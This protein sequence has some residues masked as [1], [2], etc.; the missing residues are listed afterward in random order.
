MLNS[1]VL[2]GFMLYIYIIK[3]TEKILIGGQA[4]R[5]L[6]HDRHTDDYDYLIYD[7]SDSR[8]FITSD[9]VDY[10]NAAAA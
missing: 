2:G 4:L 6:G 3:T 10:L 1:I 9:K 5:K 8:D 7:T